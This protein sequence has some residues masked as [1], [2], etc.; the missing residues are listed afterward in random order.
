[1][2]KNKIKLNGWYSDTT[3]GGSFKVFRGYADLKTLATIST[4]FYYQQNKN[5]GYQREIIVSHAKDI[6][7]FF[8][9]QSYRFIPE[10]ILGVRL[11]SKGSVVSLTAGFSEDDR[12]S[13]LNPEGGASRA[14]NISQAKR[15]EARLGKE[16]SLTIDLDELKTNV[17][18]IRRVDG[19]HR[20]FY[21]ENLTDDA[22]SPNKYVVPYCMI[23]LGPTSNRYDDFAEAM[24][25]YN[26]NQ[27]GIPIASEHGFNVLLTAGMDETR[28]F[29]E[30]TLLFCAQYLKQELQNCAQELKDVF[31][32]LPLT[33]LHTII[34][35]LKEQHLLD[36][37]EKHVVKASLKDLIEKVNQ[38]YCW[39]LTE[40][41][42]IAKSFR[43]VPAIILML[44]D[45][46]RKNAIPHWLRSYDKWIVN[47]HLL[48]DFEL[49]K[50]AEI[51][52]IFKK[53]KDNQ[54]KIIFVA[55]S[56]RKAEV[57]EAVKGMIK[58]AINKVVEKHPDI[59][60]EAI[61]VDD[62]KGKSFEVPAK[63]FADIDAAGLLIADLTD[64][65]P[66]VYCEVGYAKAKDIP[67]I[68]TFRPKNEKEG[69]AKN[70]VHTD[71]LPYKYLQYD[72]ASV[73]RDKLVNELEAFYGVTDI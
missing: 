25:F 38:Y 73:L 3:L 68:L 32:D 48:E 39:A 43:I 11:D 26:I 20:L 29:N 23:L 53:W 66:N 6:K 15:P 10:I 7:S 55:C 64:E 18:A 22:N 12:A 33:N 52:S 63:I 62:N 65:R 60:V 16:V 45:D 67:F 59:R 44:L 31:G 27:K 19:N 13:L 41:L 61:R 49:M 51:W 34:K 40:K 8:E 71:L 36:F 46:G 1:M 70:K 2:A 21:A 37:S 72:D 35:N 30:D 5:I 28:L 57:L 58:E 14:Q 56:F 50:P 54:P 4:P 42:E 9:D 69:R 17:N 47:N 24:V